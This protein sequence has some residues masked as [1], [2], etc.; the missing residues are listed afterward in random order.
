MLPDARIR[1]LVSCEHAGNMV[2]QV[3]QSLFAD[4]DEIL[5]T[6]RAYD[7]G[8]LAIA[9]LLA[10]RLNAP[11][12]FHTLTRLLFD[13]NRSAHN[14][15]LFSQFSKALSHKERRD[16]LA[17]YH[18]PYRKKMLGLINIL[19]E[20]TDVVVHIAVHSFTPELHGVVRNAEIGLLYDPA[21]HKEKDL[22]IRWQ[23]ALRQTAGKIRTRRN[24]P[25]A[26]KNDGLCTELRRRFSGEHYLG[27]ELELN[28]KLLSDKK[29]QQKE[30][31]KILVRTLKI[32][33][34]QS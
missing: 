18:S 3:F 12:Q 4:S 2:P 11:L 8:A 24:Y 30:L 7:L 33:T 28:Q 21:R 5:Q 6:H 14:R 9:R 31:A 27:I 32:A 10:K 16:L 22:C 13:M 25:Y 1:F 17:M 23:K 29:S 34:R 19:Q 15:N 20:S 26:G